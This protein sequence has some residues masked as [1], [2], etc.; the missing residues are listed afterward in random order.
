[1]NRLNEFFAPKLH[2]VTSKAELRA[3]D[4]TYVMGGENI[5]AAPTGNTSTNVARVQLL[6][7]V[8]AA[9]LFTPFLVLFANLAKKS[10]EAKVEEAHSQGDYEEFLEESTQSRTER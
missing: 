10:Y 6:Q 5:I 3:D 1:M 7:V 9:V 4:R 2:K 8:P